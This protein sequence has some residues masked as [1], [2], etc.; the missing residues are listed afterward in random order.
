MIATVPWA[1]EIE[2]GWTA[3][4][5]ADAAHYLV[6]RGEGKAPDLAGAALAEVKGLGLVDTAVTAGLT[7]QYAVVAVDQ[8]GNKST[9]SETVSA[10]AVAGEGPAISAVTVEPYGKPVKPGQVVTLSVTGQSG[11]TVTADVGALATGLALAEAG[12]TGTYT[13]AYTVKDADVG[14]TK[15]LHRVVAKL[16]DAYGASEL[17]GPELAVVGLDVLND[18]TAPVVSGASHD[19]FQ[20]AGFS[21]ALVAG[22]VVTVSVEG[23]PGGYAAFEIPGVLARTPMNET[24][25]GTYTGTYTV[26]WSDEGTALPV[27]AYLADEA[28]N[29]TSLTV[30][31]PLGARHAGAPPGDR[32][33]HAASGGQEEHHAAGGQGQRRQRR[34]RQR[35]RTGP[36]AL[37]HRGV[38]R[39]GGRRAARR[40][41]S[42]HGGRRRPRDQVGRG[43]RQLRGSGGHLHGGVRGEDRARSWPRTS[44]R[45]TWGR[46]GSTP[47][48]PPPS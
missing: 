38:H 5:S 21:G 20:V 46:A 36:D 11:G 10:T 48:W 4:P 39:R 2:L 43:D 40:P 27:V 32:E 44:P 29:E 16:T 24:Q 23:E 35:P 13:A 28:G 6:Y 45:A 14:A 15:T 31:R 12:R 37:H 19:G 33:G 8:A 47:T 41:G 30:G 42:P 25:A 9:P 26:G 7:Y 17:A 3:S 34:R 22:D 1:G 18:R